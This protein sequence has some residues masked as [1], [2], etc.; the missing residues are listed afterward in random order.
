MAGKIVTAEIAK[1]NRDE[2]NPVAWWIAHTVTAQEWREYFTMRY[3]VT[4]SHLD[5]WAKSRLGYMPG[6]D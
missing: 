3:L 6:W 1:I 4:S 2:S 5:F